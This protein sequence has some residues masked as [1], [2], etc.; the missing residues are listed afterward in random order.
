MSRAS[1][2]TGWSRTYSGITWPCDESEAPPYGRSNG[3]WMLSRLFTAVHT[4]PSGA[5]ARP[6]PL[7]TPTAYGSGA[8]PPARDP[9][10]RR[11]GRGRGEVVV[12]DVAGRPGRHVDGTVG[13]DGHALER[14]RV[15]AP[16]VRA[17]RVRQSGDDG[18]RAGRG[19]TG[20]GVGVHP[21]ALRDVQGGPGE[22]EAVRLVQPVQ[23][24]RPGRRSPAVRRQPDDRAVFR[25]RHQQRAVRRPGGEP[26]RR[27]AGEHRHRP[28]GRHEHLSGHVQRRGSQARGDDHR[29]RGQIVGSSGRR[30]PG[31]PGTRRPP[32][33]GGEQNRDRGQHRDDAS[34]RHV[35]PPGDGAPPFF[36]A[37]GRWP[38]QGCR[39]VGAPRPAGGGPPTQ[40]SSPL[41][42][43]GDGSGRGAGGAPLDARAR[44]P[45][46][47]AR[48]R[49]AGPRT[50]PSATSRPRASRP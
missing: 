44:A 19:S 14:V 25:H 28:A 7:R 3:Y 2:S 33:A 6:V 47:P 4:A 40:D 11:P 43:C 29:H 10:D 17:L 27:H 13:T 31:G 26:R 22:R 48:G 5:T 32:G 9:Q 39:A 49:P 30:R 42:R 8:P 15:L 23:Q 45:P 24:H 41:S 37:A 21:V 50:R 34:R 35:S 18:P 20:V 38:A 1:G 12:G 46:P 16:Q 36:P